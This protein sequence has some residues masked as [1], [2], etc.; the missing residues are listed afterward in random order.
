MRQ[1]GPPVRAI[2]VVSCFIG[3]AAAFGILLLNGVAWA[4]MFPSVV[5]TGVAFTIAS[6]FWYAYTRWLWRVRGFRM[7]G[8]LSPAPD[9]NGRWEGTVQRT[10]SDSPH[11]FVV[12]V[13][14]SYTS[15]RFRTFSKDS[16][17]QSIAVAVSKDDEANIF[18]V[19]AAWQTTTKKLT[20]SGAPSA[21]EREQTFRGTSHWRIEYIDNPGFKGD[22][23]RI[24][25]KYFTDR[26]TS[27]E[28]VVTRVGRKLKNG[29]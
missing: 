14:Q 15:L 13:V 16:T 6:A 29:F 2:A 3:I 20:K 19:V 10:R 26:D 4:E 12:E 11:E 1:I 7:F 27:G 17:G 9:L 21:K 24:R 23:L 8:W 25:D 28:V 22:Q 5:K 18:G